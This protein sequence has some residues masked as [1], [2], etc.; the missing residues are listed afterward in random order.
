MHLVIQIEKKK[1]GIYKPTGKVRKTN[2]VHCCCTFSPQASN[3]AILTNDRHRQ[4]EG[5]QFFNNKFVKR[6]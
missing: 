3:D 2:I 1:I 6:S 4:L 5:K